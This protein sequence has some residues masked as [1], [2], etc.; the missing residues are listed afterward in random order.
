MK[1]K[2]YADFILLETKY[3]HMGITI[4]EVI[5]NIDLVNVQKKLK[6]TPITDTE[7]TP[8]GD[9]VDLVTTIDE[10]K[11]KKN[12][13][14]SA[15]IKQDYLDKWFDRDGKQKSMIKVRFTEFTFYSGSLHLLIHT[16]F[17]PASKISALLS[18]IVFNNK[19]DPILTRKIHPDKLV[20]FLDK[21][22]CIIKGCSWKDL[23]LPNLAQAHLTGFSIDETADFKKYDKH[24]IR[25][26]VFFNIPSLDITLSVSRTATTSI[27]NKMERD[28]KEQF[29]LQNI[30]PLCT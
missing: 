26:N 11:I 2:A 4:F 7:Y 25:N 12:Q 1:I 19:D 18:K 6:I 23:D 9:L 22:K 3:K 16:A 20:R 14:V 8:E 10:I 15:V 30:L 24:G 29:I 5:K 21:Y 27:R 13:Y 28:K 17:D